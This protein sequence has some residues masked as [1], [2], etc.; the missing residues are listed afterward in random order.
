MKKS[1]KAPKVK[2]LATVKGLTIPKGR[3]PKVQQTA[4]QV[5]ASAGK[6]QPLSGGGKI[7]L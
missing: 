6:V 3:T 5:V 4:D 2:A 7:K 1:H